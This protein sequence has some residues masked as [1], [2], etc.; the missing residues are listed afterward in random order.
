MIATSCKD[1]RLLDRGG[2]TLVELVIIIVLLGILAAVAVPRFA[3]MTES[4]K[5]N[6]TRQEMMALKR[7]IVGNPEVISG[8]Q[9]VERGF[10]GDVGFAPN[11]LADLV[12]KPDSLASYDRL[13]RLGWNGP[14]IDSSSGDYLAD[15]WGVGYVY[16]PQN[17]RLQSVGGS[18][19]INISF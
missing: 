15:A 5:I 18:D 16:E 8:G 19:T 2:F 12:I 17:R 1:R 6:A 13:S 10:E 11:R 7:A 3:D 14:Y 4:S 9:H